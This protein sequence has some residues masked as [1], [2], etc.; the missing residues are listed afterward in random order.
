MT[1]FKNIIAEVN[2]DHNQQIERATQRINED[3]GRFDQLR[4]ASTARRWEQFTNGEITEE[5][6]KAYAVKREVKQIEKKRAEKLAHLE[7]IANAPELD[8]IS[9]CVEWKR[10]YMWGM[11][12][13]AYTNTDHERATGTASGCGYDKESAAVAEALNQCDSVLK[14][15]Y[16]YKERQLEE[17]KSDESRTA[18]TGRDNR[19][20]IAYGAGY[21]A[22]PYFEGGVG[23]S[24]FWHIFE[25]LGF[26]VRYN[27]GGKH[28]DY[29]TI[30]RKA[31]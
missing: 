21:S 19:N 14:A 25:L 11:N 16:T 30:T 28:S 31:A 15:L 29:Y 12:P 9:I 8:Y 2:A 26:D 1:T 4:R 22:I 17:G 18:C 23:V 27:N 13:T 20:I 6:A 3:S 7:R 10:S 24:C 5:Q